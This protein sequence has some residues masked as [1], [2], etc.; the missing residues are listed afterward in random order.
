MKRSS[1]RGLK[2]RRD[3][4]NGKVT[5]TIPFGDLSQL[6]T[7]A[8]LQCYS[9]QAT[10]LNDKDDSPK[11][12]QKRADYYRKLAHYI[13]GISLLLSDAL[14]INQSPLD[15]DPLTKVRTVTQRWRD[16]RRDKAE[17]QLIEG[18]LRSFPRYEPAKDESQT[19]FENIHKRVLAAEEKGIYA[20]A[21]TDGGDKSVAR[22]ELVCRWCKHL[23]AV[24][25][26]STDG[27]KYSVDG[28]SCTSG[29][30]H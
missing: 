29:Q 3:W 24:H 10:A 13:N 2:V 7:L 21:V 5:L 27:T 22:P 19:F 9:C 17:R 15:E 4:R 12:Q 26:K 18:L 1:F 6:L 20:Q 28:C 25:R 16:V 30:P 11:E 8:V 14:V 23:L